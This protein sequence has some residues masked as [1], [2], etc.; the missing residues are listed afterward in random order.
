MLSGSPLSTDACRA[1]PSTLPMFAIKPVSSWQVK[2]AGCWLR[3]LELHSEI[4]ST[5]FLLHC[6]A[7]LH[8][9]TSKVQT[10]WLC[11]NLVSTSVVEWS[12]PHLTTHY[13]TNVCTNLSW[14][15]MHHSQL[16]DVFSETR[17]H[18]KGRLDYMLSD[19]MQIMCLNSFSREGK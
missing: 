1:S 18:N 7:C 2:T 11:S 3:T 17:S 9:E 10:W 19:V 4:C 13:F 14:A 6:L 15:W 5:S 12:R 8:S 16:T